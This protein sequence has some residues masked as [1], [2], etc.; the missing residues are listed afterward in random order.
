MYRNKVFHY[1]SLITDE[2]NPPA[3]MHNFIY[4]IINQMSADKLLKQLKSIDSFNEKYQKGKKM[5]ILKNKEGPH[6]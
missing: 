4:N 1:G 3:R 6:S 2:K 5:G